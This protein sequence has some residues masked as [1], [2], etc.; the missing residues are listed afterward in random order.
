MAKKPQDFY[1][2]TIIYRIKLVFFSNSLT[3]TEYF[4]INQQVTKYKTLTIFQ[5]FLFLAYT[6][7]IQ[8]ILQTTLKYLITPFKAIICT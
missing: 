6:H 1:T 4:N 8:L 7:L 5:R 3:Q 2:W